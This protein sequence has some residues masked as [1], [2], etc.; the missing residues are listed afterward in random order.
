MVR[1]IAGKVIAGPRFNA[2]EEERWIMGV[3]GR[4]QLCA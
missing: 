1:S 3:F 4:S 2:T